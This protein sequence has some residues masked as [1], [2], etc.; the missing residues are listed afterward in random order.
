LQK[1]GHSDDQKLALKFRIS[2]RKDGFT[3]HE[4]HAKGGSLTFHRQEIQKTLLNHVP[5][6]C[7]IHLSHRLTHCEEGEDSVK[8]FFKNGVEEEADILIAADGIKSVVRESFLN[9]GIF[10]T[11]TDTFRGLIPKETF[12][13]SY[14][15]HI[16]LEDPIVYCG[17]NGHLVVYPISAGRIINVVAFVS[18]VEN[19][20]KPLKDEEIRDATRE[21][22]LEHFCGWE[23]PVMQMLGC[24]EKPSRW[25]IRDL[26]PM[27]TYVSR[28]I[29]LV[30]DA[31]HTMTPHLG[32]G[33][34][35]AMED[36]YVLGKLLSDGVDKWPVVLQA[37][38][39]V[40]HPAANKI[41]RNAR[42]MGFY[43]D[44]NAPGFE[45]I[46]DI[47]QA[48]TP[49][50]ITL[51]CDTVKEKWSWWENNADEDLMKAIKFLREGSP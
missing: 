12:A 18:K 29:A 9:E 34:G 24:I 15:D 26:R 50:Q 36:A 48:L 38:N 13:K 11:G 4:L 46:T 23:E 6:F 40:R 33:A 35:Q 17:K 2:D 47:G 42:E 51:I 37:Y 44:L 20:G 30:G 10:Y 41:Q 8:L 39:F 49:E 1:D 22:V 45:N 28:R 5:E 25:A 19:E 31:A 32:A 21:E 7:H 27:K 43:Y 3:F 14:P 16:N